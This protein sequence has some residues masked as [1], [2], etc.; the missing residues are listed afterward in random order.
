MLL[1]DCIMRILHLRGAQG[2]LGGLW[3]EKVI[4]K[5]NKLEVGPSQAEGFL[6]LVAKIAKVKRRF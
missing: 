1:A 4:M 5:G 3:R 6:F 2:A